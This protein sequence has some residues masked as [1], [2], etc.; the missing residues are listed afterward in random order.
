MLY[1]GGRA[2]DRCV[3]ALSL[4]QFQLTVLV[5]LR[6]EML[7][8][9]EGTFSKDWKRPIRAIELELILQER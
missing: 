4:I 6:S 3:L 2:I 8:A 7:R 5:Y 9:K 1:L